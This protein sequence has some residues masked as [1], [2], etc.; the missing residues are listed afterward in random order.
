MTDRVTVES[1]DEGKAVVDANGNEVGVVT[2]VRAGKAY[3]DPEP[4]LTDSVASRLGWGSVDEEDEPL[5]EE[6]VAAIT[7][8]EIRLDEAVRLG[9]E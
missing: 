6:A 9:E 3:V 1:E 8:E 5:P 7:D 2:G 4:G